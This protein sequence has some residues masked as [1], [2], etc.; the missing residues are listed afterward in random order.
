MTR[1]QYTDHFR[2][3]RVKEMRDG[4]SKKMIS[5]AYGVPLSTLKTWSLADRDP[6]YRALAHNQPTVAEVRRAYV[7]MG[8]RVPYAEIARVLKRDK[9]TIIAWASD[10]SW[11]EAMYTYD[12][13][14]KYDVDDIEDRAIVAQHLCTQTECVSDRFELMLA[15]AYGPT[16][17][18]S[19]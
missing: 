12:E 18:E 2:M 15:A 5:Q 17:K 8:L 9:R 6:Q 14:K 13:S 16:P 4:I 11:H 7:M 1:K 19:E 3:E 10:P